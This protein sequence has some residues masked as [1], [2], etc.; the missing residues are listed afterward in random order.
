MVLFTR[1]S[2]NITLFV[3]Q[4]VSFIIMFWAFKMHI[5]LFSRTNTLNT[6]RS[7]LLLHEHINTNILDTGVCPLGKIGAW[8]LMLWMITLMILVYALNSKKEFIVGW[9]NFILNIII[10][11]LCLLLGNF[12]L[13]VRATPYFILQFAISMVL[14]QKTEDTNNS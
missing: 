3:L 8:F 5:N 14:L 9:I 4:T 1:K 2:K 7:N 6:N 10:L 13:A 12:P 11:I